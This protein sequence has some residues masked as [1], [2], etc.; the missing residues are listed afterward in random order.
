[1]QLHVFQI[2]RTLPFIQASR[3]SGV[4]AAMVLN[5]RDCNIVR[6]FLARNDHRES[7]IPTAYN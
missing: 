7:E 1:M 2:K 4:L 6:G 3:A 5:E